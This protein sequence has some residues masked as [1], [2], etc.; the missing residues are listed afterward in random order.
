MAGK[1]KLSIFI[2]HLENRK[3][4]LMKLNLT[5]LSQY[6]QCGGLFESLIEMDNGEMPIGT[7]RNNLLSQSVG[8]YVCFIDDDDMVADFYVEEILKAIETE[9]D[10]VGFNGAIVHKNGREEPVTYRLGNTAINRK[11]AVTVCGIGHL[12]PVKREIALS[13]K[14]PDK[15]SGEDYEY[16]KALQ[17]KLVSEVFIDKTMYYYLQENKK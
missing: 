9:P 6:N 8:D 12:N 7:K 5:L 10:C 17:A 14:F 3:S 11:G 1:W 2:C 15:S 16:A 13:V 4:Q